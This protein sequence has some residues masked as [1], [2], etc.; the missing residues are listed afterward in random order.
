MD[1]L[2]PEEVNIILQS[3][4]TETPPPPMLERKLQ[5]A[6]A[7]IE[8]II[9][10]SQEP[11]SLETPIGNDENSELSDFVEDENLPGPMD[12]TSGQMLR[13]QLHRILNE[14]GEREREVLEMRFGLKD[15]PPHT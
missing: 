6:V 1:L 10:I 2:E 15:G 9:N 5:R 12:A 11:M 8:R 7:K 13:E 14:L 4:V 3:R